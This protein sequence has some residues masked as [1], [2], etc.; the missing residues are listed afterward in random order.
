MSSN[1]MQKSI[2]N[3]Q[4]RKNKA[5]FNYIFRVRGQTNKT[6]DSGDS[7]NLKQKLYV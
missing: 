5:R 1:C 2:K 4:N 3:S 7:L 6:A